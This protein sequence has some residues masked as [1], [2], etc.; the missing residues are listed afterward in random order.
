MSNHQSDATLEVRH[1]NI[2]DGV[3]HH[4]VVAQSKYGCL[5]GCNPISIP[6]FTILCHGEPDLF[7]RNQLIRP[8]KAI[9]RGPGPRCVRAL[10]GPH[11]DQSLVSGRSWTWRP[12]WWVYL[13]NSTKI[14]GRSIDQSDVKRK[15]TA[16][17]SF[18]I[19]L[20]SL[21]LKIKGFVRFRMFLGFAAS[22]YHKL[23]FYTIH[24]ASSMARSLLG[25]AQV[26]F[27]KW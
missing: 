4:F 18:W 13:I 20:G 23:Q 8:Q 5:K 2:S 6:W 3:W 22:L 9:D 14:L 21:I 19:F 1:L 26:W 10:I 16:N 27:E 12:G 15:S 25:R 7:Q 24:S 17:Y 11:H